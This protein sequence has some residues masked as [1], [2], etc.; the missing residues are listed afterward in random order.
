MGLKDLIPG[1][2]GPSDEKVQSHIPDS[3]KGDQVTP[4]SVK[5]I[6]DLLDE[7]EK[8]HYIGQSYKTEIDEEEHKGTKGV[9]RVVATDRRIAIKIP[10]FTKKR[11]TIK[12]FG[13]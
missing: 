13:F 3:Q 10:H 7:N 5:K 12:L 2:D 6:L 8:V 1:G 11:V 9:G 4:K